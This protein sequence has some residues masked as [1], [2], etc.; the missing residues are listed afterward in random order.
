[1]VNGGGRKREAR[2]GTPSAELEGRRDRANVHR[3]QSAWR[4]NGTLERKREERKA[5]R[6]EKGDCGKERAA[7]GRRNR[8]GQS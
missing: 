7:R 8:K 3:G 6:E 1:V 5:F 4:K 2:A